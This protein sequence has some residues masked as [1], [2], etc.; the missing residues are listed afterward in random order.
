MSSLPVLLFAL[1]VAPKKTGTPGNSPGKPQGGG[2]NLLKK[3]TGG[4]GPAGQMIKNPK[5][6]F[7]P[8]RQLQQ[9]K[10]QLKPSALLK[11][12][13]DKLADEAKK[14]VFMLIVTNPEISI[15]IA[16][17]ILIIL[18]II[19]LLTGQT[20]QQ[21]QQQGQG[22]NVPITSDVCN[23]STVPN[24]YRGTSVCT[25][26]V[27]YSGSATDIVITSTI[28][29]GTTYVSAGQGG[30]YDQTANTVTWDAKK[31]KLQLNPV[32]FSVTV[33]VR[34]TTTKTNVKVWNAYSINPTGLQ[35]SGGTTN[36][37]YVAPNTDNCGGKYT[38]NMASNY[39]LHKNFGDPQCNFNKS[40]V[41][42]L[43]QQQD[44]KDASIF[45]TI[46]VPCESG[47]NPN[48]WAPPSTGTPN[49]QG[50]WGLFQMGDS[51]PPGGPVSGTINDRGDVNWPMQ[52]LSATN[53]AKST[54]S[55]NSNQG[56]YWS[57]LDWIA[58]GR[59]SC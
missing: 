41:Y 38:S 56:G 7:N 31:S 29:P 21:L 48:T 55:L 9:A 4:M 34:V 39:L 5:D 32:N 24:G 13:K 36:T 26:T 42:K 33:T 49:S 40:Q 51:R 59:G 30:T 58:H 23:P 3:S 20:N 44:P 11:K 28:L 6:Q 27:S 18:F 22:Q 14:K 50:A 54:P 10:E 43:L 8:K 52:I 2:I 15:P 37:A 17:V 16:V 47:W 46:I 1:F 19:F 25:I 45:F 53:K 12:G 57:Y 35:S